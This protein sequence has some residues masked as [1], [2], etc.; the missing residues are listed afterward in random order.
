[1]AAVA[2]ERGL[3]HSQAMQER[4]AT[5]IRELISRLQDADRYRRAF[6]PSSAA[7]HRAAREVER[8]SRRIF[9]EATAEEEQARR[10]A[11]QR[12]AT[13]RSPE[14]QR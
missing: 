14:A 13:S 4:Q 1:V 6:R 5:V 11:R 10:Q 7:Y 9:E 3:L 2:A 12:P 8:L